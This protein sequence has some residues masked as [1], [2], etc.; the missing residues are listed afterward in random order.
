MAISV[1]WVTGVIHVPKTY[2]TLVVGSVY[3]L[4]VNLFRKDLRD[5]EDSEDGRAWSRILNH[6][7]EVS[8]SGVSYARIVEILT[9]YTIE[10]EDGN[11]SVSCLNANHNI[12]DVKVVNSVSLIVNNSAGLVNLPELQSSAFK[13][14]VALDAV[15]GI[16]GT[17]YPIG[18]H[19]VPS[20]NA[21]NAVTIA[22]REGAERIVLHGSYTLGTGDDISGR[23]MIGENAITTF[24]T[25]EPAAVTTNSKFSSMFIV[26]STFD[27][28]TYAE[29]CYL[30]TISDFEGYAELCILSRTIILSNTEP[31]YFVDC[32]SACYG[33]GLELPVLDMSA[34]N[35]HVAFR[36]WSGPIKI[37][38][39][40][41]ANN[42][43]CF[44]TVS[45]ATIVVDSSCTAGTLIPRG[46]MTITN[47]GNMTIDTTTTLEPRILVDV[48]QFAG[49]DINN[50]VVISGNGTTESILTVDGKAMTITPTSI[51]RTA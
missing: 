39:S 1:N 6:N 18:T 20:S 22:E 2:L 5:L 12:A 17:D 9:P 25:I 42:T 16:A 44:D 40:T 49:H 41:D 38:N 28:K 30:D 51:I 33:V 15:E 50:P 10:F 21:Q 36:N 7:T 13:G 48:H 4:D 3:S 43:I 11:Y 35:L 19:K 27:G 31:T 14:E 45:A 29:K 8:L 34:G 37:I 47:N 26:N 24:L 32:K 46:I 23:H